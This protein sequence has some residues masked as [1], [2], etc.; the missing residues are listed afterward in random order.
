MTPR[1]QNQ[2]GQTL[3]E[4][5]LIYVLL[6]IPVSFAIIFTAQLL[7]IWHSAIEWTRDGARYAATHC[8]QAGGGNVISYMRTHVPTNIDQDQFTGG[9][10]EV[11][12]QYFT[13]NAESGTLDEFACESECTP[14]CVPDV[15]TVRVLNYEFRRFFAYLGLSPI[16][17]PDFA[18]TVPIESAGCDPESGTCTP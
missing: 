11:Q 13:R 8:Y 17:M 14:D 16:T 12:I 3:V 6:L 7:W 2:K 15:V 1:R 4:F 9:Q 10:A 5:S 18:T